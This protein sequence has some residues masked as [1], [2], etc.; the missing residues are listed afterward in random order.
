LLSDLETQNAQLDPA[1][2]QDATLAV[3][4]SNNAAAETLF[5]ELERGHGGLNGA[6]SAVSDTL[7]R[8][9]DGHVQVNTTPNAGGFTTWG[10]TEWSTAGEVTFYRALA[11]GCLLASS[12]D[13]QWVLSLMS[14]IEPDQRWGAGAANFGIPAAFKGGWGPDSD[15]SGGYLVRQSAIVGSGPHGYVLSMIAAPSDGSFATGTSMLS[16]TAAWI[17]RTF[18]ALISSPPAGCS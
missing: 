5:S 17:A 8:A 14:Q 9:G 6:S 11:R 7:A 3:E 12:S 18:P 10:Q 2:R 13:T 4:Q 1:S 16:Q 15:H